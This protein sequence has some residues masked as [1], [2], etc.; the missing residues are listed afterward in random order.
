MMVTPCQVTRDSGP[1]VLD[2]VTGDF[3]SG[4]SVIFDGYCKVQTREGEVLDVVTGSSDPN[5]Q[6]YS[7]HLPVSA[8]PFK[9]GDLVA[10]P[11]RVFKVDGL[12]KKTWQ[13]AQRVPVVEV[14]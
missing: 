2:P 14:I 12:H 4:V 6:R 10:V 5:V 8:G 13:T 1:P 9:H 3:T 11:G 7:I